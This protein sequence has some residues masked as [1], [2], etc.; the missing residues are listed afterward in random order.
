MVE[1]N[2]QQSAFLLECEQEFKNRYT[3][4]DEE[5]SK[6]A[7]QSMSQP[8]I[9]DNW[10]SYRNHNDRHHHQQR[11]NRQYGDRRGAGGHQSHHQHS[12]N[13]YNRRGYSNRQEPYD[14][15][16]RGYDDRPRYGDRPRSYYWPEMGTIMTIRNAM[17]WQIENA[18]LGDLYASCLLLVV[19][20]SFLPNVVFIFHS[21]FELWIQESSLT[22]SVAVVHGYCLALLVSDVEKK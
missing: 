20:T 12:N 21:S 8:P 22:W 11:G 9:V 6:L 18:R 2:E 17:T 16:R 19:Y 14:Q 1:L 13:S 15:T 3:D 5:Y 7:A 4:Q 10:D